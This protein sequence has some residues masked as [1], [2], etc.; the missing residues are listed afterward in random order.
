MSTEAMNLEGSSE[1]YFLIDSYSDQIEAL[2]GEGYTP[3]TAVMEELILSPLKNRVELLEV[4]DKYATYKIDN[5]I[6]ARVLSDSFRAQMVDHWDAIKKPASITAWTCTSVAAVSVL[7]A[8]AG[9]VYLVAVTPFAIYGAY[10]HFFEASHA[11]K[12]ANRWGTSPAETIAKHRTDAYKQGFAHIYHNGAVRKTL[13]PFEVAYLFEKYLDTTCSNLLNKQCPT[14]RSKKAWLDQFRTDS[15]LSSSFLRCAY[16]QILWPYS[17]ISSRFEQLASALQTIQLEFDLARQNSRS[18]TDARLKEIESQRTLMLNLPRVTRDEA[19]RQAD[20][21]FNE[22]FIA[23]EEYTQRRDKHEQEVQR[24]RA[25]YSMVAAPINAYFDG[26]ISEAKQSLAHTLT[27]IAKEEAT[28]F[29]LYYERARSILEAAR[30][31]RNP[32][33][34]PPAIDIP[35]FHPPQLPAFELRYGA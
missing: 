25:L 35:L 17:E 16:G 22:G 6:R 1:A 21:Q 15:P 4:Q 18:D 3:T 31:A 32:E 10:T 14:E 8:L 24:V 29:S 30:N 12:Q 7:A 28:A 13:L 34:S 26:K 20:K 9:A 5:C 33:F 27:A 19:I 11:S 23:G 2:G